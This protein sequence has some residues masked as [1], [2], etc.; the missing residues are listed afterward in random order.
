MK[1]KYLIYSTILAWSLVIFLTG[2]YV[3]SWT[4]P[5]QDP[6]SGNIVPSFS[7]WITSGS[8][9]YYNDGNVGIGITS[10]KTKLEVAGAIKIGSE[11]TCGNDTEGAIRYVSSGQEKKLEICNGQ[12]WNLII[13]IFIPTVSIKAN[14]SNGPISVPYNSVATLSWVSENATSCEASG[15]WSGTKDISGSEL[16]DYLIS[17][18]TYTITCA[19]S[20]G[21]T[22]DS[23][24]VNVGAFL[25][26]ESAVTF[27]YKG[28]SVTYGTVESQGKCWMDRNL[29]ASRVAI[30]STDTNA[31]GDLFQWG[32]LDDGH[33]SRTSGTTSTRSSSDTP[34]HSNFILHSS[35]P[36]D[37]RNPQNNN[38]W[39]G[40]DGINNPCPPGWRI[41]TAVEWQTELNS[42]VSKNNNGAYASPLKLTMGGYRDY[43]TGGVSAAG[44]RG[45]YRSSTISGT[46]AEHLGFD[47]SSASMTA[48]GR[49]YGQS[50]RCIKN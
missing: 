46:S 41:P 35:S 22:S 12:I 4:Y 21:E 18:K 10:P 44:S 15:N 50:V 25:C 3:I 37:W 6:P 42:W 20:G 47:S 8:D 26:G 14:D 39:Q 1:T 36:N 31:Y 40:V 16:T 38:L 9:I 7:Q 11:T 28:S 13:E 49:A 29:G 33:Q 23:V 5:T 30:S 24:T 34:G 27:T 19:G 32:R 2:N 45:R 48:F 17:A 43:S